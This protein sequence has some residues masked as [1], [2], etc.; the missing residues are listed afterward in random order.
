MSSVKRCFFTNTFVKYVC[1]M[2]KNAARSFVKNAPRQRRCTKTIYRT[3]RKC[4]IMRSVL[5]KNKKKTRVVFCWYNVYIKQE[6]KTAKTPR[7]Q[8][9]C[10]DNEHWTPV[11]AK[12]YC[13]TEVWLSSV[14]SEVAWLSTNEVVLNRRHKQTRSVQSC[15]LANYR[16]MSQAKSYT[17]R[18]R[19]LADISNQSQMRFFFKATLSLRTP[20][21]PLHTANQSNKLLPFWRQ[22][23]IA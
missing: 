13:K 17:A 22:L 23:E 16:Q 2:Q 4:P 18:P 11:S 19:P 21:I 8:S 10:F 7:K 3:V 20:I 14:I 5:E 15:T 12:S 9:L 1:V 6:C